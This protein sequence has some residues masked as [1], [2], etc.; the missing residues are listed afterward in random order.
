[1]VLRH[2]LQR[3]GV[4]RRA[5]LGLLDRR[6]LELLEQ[7]ARSCGVELTLNSSPAMRVDLAARGGR[8]RSASSPAE[9]VEEVAVDLDRRRAP[10]SPA[11][12]R[13]V[14]RTARRGRSAR[15]RR[16]PRRARRR[17]GAPRR[18]AGRSRRW[19]RRRRGRGCPGLGVGRRGPPAR[20]TAASSSSRSYF[21]SPGSRRYAMTAVSWSSV[22]T[23]APSPC[24]S[25]L[26]R[27]ATSG[28][29][30]GASS[31]LARPRRRQDRRGPRRRSR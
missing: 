2:L 15:G 24:I 28:G 30:P 4:G 7:H 21:P 8:T 3:V 26:A 29:P 10:S 6:E 31:A 17:A 13:A 9:L 22:R 18:R 16:A 20:G 11:P 1:M 23:S 12:A 5:G 27:C 25:S 14:A 19:R